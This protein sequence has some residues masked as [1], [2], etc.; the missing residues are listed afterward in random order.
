MPEGLVRRGG[1]GSGGQG[2]EGPHH[3]QGGEEDRVLS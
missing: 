1:S 2:K 3:E